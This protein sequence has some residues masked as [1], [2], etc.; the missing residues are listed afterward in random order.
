MGTPSARAAATANRVFASWCFESYDVANG[1]GASRSTRS[2]RMSS[3]CKY[4]SSS[5]SGGTIAMPSAGSASISSAFARAMFSSEPRNSRCAGP[6]FVITPMFGRT[7]DAS[8]SICPGPRIPSSLMQIS[9]SSSIRQN[10][11]GTPISVL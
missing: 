2:M 1:S 8:H 9:V 4:G 3:R 7:N 10:V 5:G 11:S 6:M